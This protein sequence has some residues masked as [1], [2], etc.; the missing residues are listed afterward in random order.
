MKTPLAGFDRSLISSALAA[1]HETDAILYVDVD[2]LQKLPLMRILIA[3]ESKELRA[4]MG[5]GVQRVFLD[6]YIA[7]ICFQLL[8]GMASKKYL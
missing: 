8:P 4:E 5:S 6:T 1:R 3:M 2:R 7:L